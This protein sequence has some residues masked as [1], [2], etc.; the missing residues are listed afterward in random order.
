MIARILVVEDEK[1]IQLALKGLL[2]REGYELDLADDGKGALAFLEENT[3]DLV[4]TDLALGRGITGM[5]V[6]KAVKEK[7][8]ETGVVMITAAAPSF[9]MPRSAPFSGQKAPELRKS[10]VWSPT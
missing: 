6:L 5:D 1:A 8:P 9:S 2:S 3:Y 4:I 7:R 10:G